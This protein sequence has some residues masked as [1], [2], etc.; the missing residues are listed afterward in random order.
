VFKIIKALS[1]LFRSED[2]HFHVAPAEG[3]RPFAWSRDGQWS[4]SIESLRREDATS[5]SGDDPDKVVTIRSS[6]VLRCRVE[7]F[8]RPQ[9][10]SVSNSGTFAVNDI[11]M[12]GD[13]LGPD[14]GLRVF[15]SD[16]RE[17]AKLQLGAAIESPALSDGGDWLAFYTLSAPR[18]SRAPDDGDS[19][20]LVDA[21]DGKILWRRELPERPRTVA[22]S[23]CGKFV[24]LKR[25]GDSALRFSLDGHFLDSAQV[26]A[27]RLEADQASEY[28]YALFN[29]VC[30]GWPS[31][32]KGISSDKRGALAANLERSL[33]K[34]MSPKTKARANRMIGEL[35]ECEGDV[36]GA[37]AAYEAAL[38]LHEGV[39]VKRRL[40][41]LKKS[42]G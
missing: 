11:G 1:S 29:R 31:D 5:W 32:L 39:G 4:A 21:R 12:A 7:G 18:D 36:S 35:R 19:L 17:I 34:K 28:G 2:A 14:T 26:E 23:E 27:E 6:D 30:E 24:I 8:R 40:A 41:E 20:F 37:I 16:G 13:F 9:D 42:N 22:F 15:L 25:D 10:V 38:K 3:H 33:A